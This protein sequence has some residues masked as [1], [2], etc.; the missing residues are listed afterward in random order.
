MV[1]GDDRASDQEEPI[2]KDSP[3]IFGPD[4]ESPVGHQNPAESETSYLSYG[5]P[6]KEVTYLILK[7]GNEFTSWIL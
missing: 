5:V 1:A 3:D 6:G 2:E 7:S 4:E